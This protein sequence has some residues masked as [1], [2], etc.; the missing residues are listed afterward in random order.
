M[1]L[2]FL[3]TQFSFPCGSKL[4]QPTHIPL[5]VQAMLDDCPGSDNSVAWLHSL[6]ANPAEQFITISSPAAQTHQHRHIKGSWV[7][8][9]SDF[10]ADVTSGSNTAA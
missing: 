9:L 4:L 6:S 8:V 3:S 1:L 7:L 2:T 5:G 10:N